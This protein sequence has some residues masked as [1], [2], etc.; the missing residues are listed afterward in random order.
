MARWLRRHYGAGPIH[1]AGLA[2]CFAVAA[3]ALAKVLGETGWKEILFWFAICVILHDLIIW[4]VYGIA[5]RVALRA[6]DGSRGRPPAVPWINHVRVP[7]IISA[8]LLAMFFPLI[9]RLSNSYY[10]QVTGF[11]ENVY[12]VNWLAVTGALFAG[13]ALAYAIRVAHARRRMAGTRSRPGPA[14][15]GGSAPAS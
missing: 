7:V 11:N 8:L 3:Y 9:L 5:D 1:L 14:P 15:G 12:I 10:Q 6:Q 13:S 2:A 4:P